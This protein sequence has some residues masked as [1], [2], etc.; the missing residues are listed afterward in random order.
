MK[1]SA[2]NKRFS[3]DFSLKIKGPE[4]NT[5]VHQLG[6]NYAS[7]QYWYYHSQ[8]WRVIA[9][10]SALW[11]CPTAANSIES[12]MFYTCPNLTDK[13]YVSLIA[14]GSHHA[15]CQLKFLDKLTSKKSSVI[16]T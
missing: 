14:S 15:H 10:L 2:T 3:Y 9:A 1:H 7:H 6:N 11:F 13:N 8:T 16:Y 12:Y 5:G 4:N